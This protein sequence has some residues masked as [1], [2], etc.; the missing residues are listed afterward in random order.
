MLTLAHRLPFTQSHLPQLPAP[1]AGFPLLTSGGPGPSHSA[2]A[3]PELERVQLSPPAL[4]CFSVSPSS[5]L[6]WR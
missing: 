3:D 1:L 2:S 4:V 6:P 5:V